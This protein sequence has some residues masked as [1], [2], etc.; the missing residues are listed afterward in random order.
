MRYEAVIGMEV[1]AQLL[2][3]SKMFCGCRAEV[4]GAEPNTLVCPVCLGMPGV[5]PVINQKAVEYT[6]MTGLA[7][8]CQISEFSRFARKNYNYPDLVKGYQ[9]SQYELPLCYDGWLEIVVD[10]TA[11]R[12]RIER[13]HL[14]EDTG[15]LFHRGEYSL[16]DYNRSGVPLMEI[17]SRPDMR[18][19]AEAYAYLTKLR[20]ILRY[21]G[22]SSGDMEKGAM[23]CEV[24]VSL[25]PVGTEGLGTKVEIKNL[26]SFRSVKM[27]L[28]YEIQ[29]QAEIL[30]Q[31]G[32][33]EQ[34]TMGWDEEGQRTV[35][36]RSKEF[37]H[38]YRYFPEP[39]LP[40]LEISRAWVEELR[41]RLPELPDAKRERFVTQYGLSAYDAEVL[42][43]EQEVA[44]YFEHCVA[45]YPEPKTVAN[46]ISGDLF[47]RMK[48]AG[49]SIT[50]IKVGPEALAELLNLVK[51]GTINLNTARQVFGL[52]LESGQ[53][54]REII[55]ERGLA[56]ISDTAELERV[57]EEVLAANPAQVQ[58]YLSGKEA[59][60]RWLMGQVMKATRGQANPQVVSRLLTEKLQA[61]RGSV[62][63]GEEDNDP[64]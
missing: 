48:E 26:N 55:A 24:N 11:K 54:A 52:M 6:I 60:A 29:R 9:I 21:L 3:Q 33:I 36:Q 25:R 50:E 34:V 30:E 17:V 32:T 22:V 49:L 51:D 23:R 53:S 38:D 44:D 58:Q 27:A 41:S 47:R 20:Q 57:V 1:H 56:Q 16:V 35:L 7:L 64:R 14:E 63:R 31:G 5:L 61:R 43:A 13:V 4:F 8:N 2:T 19:A 39:D 15:K 45:L 28:E 37:A 42:A 46:W 10:G 12:I 40:P 18:S 62:E 59:V